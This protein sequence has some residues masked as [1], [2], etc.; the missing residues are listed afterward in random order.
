MYDICTPTRLP[1]PFLNFQNSNE[2][3]V[4]IR[5]TLDSRIN[6]MQGWD[7]LCFIAPVHLFRI[8]AL[9]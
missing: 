9:R 7:Q 3:L 8:Q 4:R 1:H 5:R 2:S 6:R